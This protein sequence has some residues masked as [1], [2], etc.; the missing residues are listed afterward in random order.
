M[1]IEMFEYDREP[2]DDTVVS[3]ADALREYARTARG[4]LRRILEVSL[5]HDPVEQ[6]MEAIERRKRWQEQVR[7]STGASSGQPSG[8]SAA[9]AARKLRD[10]LKQ[11]NQQKKKDKEETERREDRAEEAGRIARARAKKRRKH[12]L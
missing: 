4:P 11:A 1:S 8:Q 10:K 5:S 3:I 6:E 12:G 7:S 9:D 2:P